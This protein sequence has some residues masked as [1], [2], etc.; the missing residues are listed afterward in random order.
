MKLGYPYFI[1]D[2]DVVDVNYS[3]LMEKKILIYFFVAS[4][5]LVASPSTASAMLTEN[6]SPAKQGIKR[7]VHEVACLCTG[8]CAKGWKDSVEKKNPAQAAAF[9]CGMCA[10]GCVEYITRD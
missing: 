2:E 9:F 1:D 4:A 5:I 3:K 8:W 7:K 6:K 10:F